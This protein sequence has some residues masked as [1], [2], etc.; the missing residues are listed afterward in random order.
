MS[1]T[2]TITR[3]LRDFF[4][5]TWSPVIHVSGRLIVGQV[6]YRILKNRQLKKSEKCFE[7]EVEGGHS[8]FEGFL[9]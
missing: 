5:E 2:S 4:I 1:A 6:S 7:N 3:A 8:H 9:G